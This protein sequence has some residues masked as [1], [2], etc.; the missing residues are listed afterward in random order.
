M[1]ISDGVLGSDLQ[2]A[3]PS[4][5]LSLM[6]SQETT[7]QALR[8]QFGPHVLMAYKVDA[9]SVKQ[10]QRSPP[11]RRTICVQCGMTASNV[12]CGL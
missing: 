3:E 5:S 1:E 6:F 9:D 4:V 8:N 7:G 10:Q 12:N 2:P 11:Q